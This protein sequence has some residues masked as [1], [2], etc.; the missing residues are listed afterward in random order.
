[1]KQGVDDFYVF[2]HPPQYIDA[3]SLE[4]LDNPLVAIAHQDHP[5]GKKKSI[6]LADLCNEP[7]L[8]REKGLGY[9]LLLKRCSRNITYS[10]ILK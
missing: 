4:F 7:F 8:M 2:S 10:L 5:L 6:S 3:Q 9:G 1:M